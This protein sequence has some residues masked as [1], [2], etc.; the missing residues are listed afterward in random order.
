M[1]SH[2]TTQ[3]TS[4]DEKEDINKIVKY[5]DDSHL[6]LKGVIET[7]Q[8]EA[9]KQKEGFRSMLLGALDSSLLGKKFSR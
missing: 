6:L 8:I 3:I 1:Y 5:L 9:K 4:H 7:I 2:N